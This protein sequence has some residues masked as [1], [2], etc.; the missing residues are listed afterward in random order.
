MKSSWKR[1]TR[2]F[3]PAAQKSKITRTIE[4]WFS[5]M[6]HKQRNTHQKKLRKRHHKKEHMISH[7]ID[8][9]GCEMSKPHNKWHVILFTYG[10]T[11]EHHIK[12]IHINIFACSAKGDKPLKNVRHC[13]CLRRKKRKLYEHHSSKKMSKQNPHVFFGWEIYSLC[14]KLHFENVGLI[15]PSWYMISNMAIR[16]VSPTLFQLFVV[17]KAVSPH[18]LWRYPSLFL[19]KVTLNP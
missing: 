14:R 5:F 12:E 19:K 16:Y 8:I 6:Q 11:C 1:H 10:G 7:Q 2:F 4:T 9:S 3:S 17:Q 13:L 18:I 15:F